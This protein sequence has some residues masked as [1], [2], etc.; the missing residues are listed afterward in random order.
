[1]CFPEDDC[2]A[3]EIAWR[4]EKWRR[5]KLRGRKMQVLIRRKKVQG[6]KMQ[7]ATSHWQTE[8]H[9]MK[10]ENITTTDT[11]ASL[12]GWNMQD[13]TTAGTW[14]VVFY[15]NYI[16]TLKA[17]KGSC[18]V[19][20][21]CT[22]FWKLNFWRHDELVSILLVVGGFRLVPSQKW[23]VNISA[24]TSVGPFPFMGPFTSIR[25][26]VTLLHLHL[27]FH[28]HQG[29]FTCVPPIEGFGGSLRQFWI[30]SGNKSKRK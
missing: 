23:P 30:K 27:A 17:I 13:V 25:F 6:W 26:W 14:C 16:I 1:M 21:K 15:E 10:M 22:E 20:K 18:H 5:R 4:L 29:L 8:A 24:F 3:T 11:S 2:G 7:D 28:Y 12:Q 19:H 9:S